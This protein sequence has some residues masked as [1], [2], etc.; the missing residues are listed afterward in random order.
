MKR[1]EI[2]I[3]TVLFL[4]FI[5]FIVSALHLITVV[6]TVTPFSVYGTPLQI[7]IDLR[8]LFIIIV[9]LC[10]TYLLWRRKRH[11]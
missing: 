10:L 9:A 8:F 3:Q 2:T 1:A 4:A 5:G 7:T 11:A 6:Y